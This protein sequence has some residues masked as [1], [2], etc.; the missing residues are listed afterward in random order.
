MSLTFALAISLFAATAE[1]QT[2]TAPRVA[3]PRDPTPGSEL[4]S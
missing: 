4:R 1:L 2:V 3:E